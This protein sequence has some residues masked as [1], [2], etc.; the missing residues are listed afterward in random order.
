AASVS[1]PVKQLKAFKKIELT[2]GQQQTVTLSLKPDDLSFIG[3]NLKRII[4]PG[5]V[6]VMIGN[7][8]RSFTLIPSSESSL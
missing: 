5:E 4:E 2:P 8:S 6:K 7:E 3:V 1:R